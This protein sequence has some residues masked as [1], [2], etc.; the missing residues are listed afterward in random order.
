MRSLIAFL[1]FLI[2]S[3]PAH[4][5]TATPGGAIT[6]TP[7]VVDTGETATVTLSSS[8]FFDLADVQDGQI[9]IRPNDSV[10]NP[11]IVSAT[12]QRLTLSFQIAPDARPG[13]RSLLIRNNA[14]ATIVAVDIAFHLGPHVCRPACQSP[15][16][17]ENHVCTGCSPPCGDNERCE[18]TVCQ[19]VSRCDP[20]PCSIGF[21]CKNDRC[22]R[23]RR[24]NPPCQIGQF[25]NDGV[26]QRQD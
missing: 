21:I 1:A 4:A 18:G 23:P 22:V 19:P 12:A 6:V 24:C 7:A 13:F 26:C 2:L 8:G 10:T 9:S 17:C 11:R 25:C 20:P 5:E 16:R 3:I 15:Q 14:G